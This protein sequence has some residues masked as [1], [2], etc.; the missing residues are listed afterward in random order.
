[1]NQIFELTIGFVISNERFKATEKLNR[2]IMILVLT[3]CIRFM[4]FE[5]LFSTK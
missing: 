3:L 5:H 2:G 1:M 4:P